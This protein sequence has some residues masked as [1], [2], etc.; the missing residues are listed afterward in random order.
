MPW[1]PRRP[2]ADRV[3][4]FELSCYGPEDLH[5]RFEP[6]GPEYVVK[7]DGLLRVELSL[8][9]GGDPELQLI[10]GDNHI[11]IW[12]SPAVQV[13]AFNKAGDALTFLM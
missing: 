8:P 13:Q 4:R 11:T 12:C 3:M 2:I 7:D 1:A 5:V 9:G 10:H 6:I